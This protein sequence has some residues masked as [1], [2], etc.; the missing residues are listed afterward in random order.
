ML[1]EKEHL[2]TESAELFKEVSVLNHKNSELEDK[3]M[4]FDEAKTLAETENACLKTQLSNSENGIL[5]LVFPFSL[6]I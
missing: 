6:I 4:A 1:S 2:T 5:S 3:L